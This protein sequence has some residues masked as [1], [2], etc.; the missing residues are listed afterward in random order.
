[1]RVFC[2]PFR[3]KSNPR[4]SRLEL[5]GKVLDTKANGCAMPDIFEEASCPAN[6]LN[7]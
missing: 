3:N 7:A 5:S 1:M 6:C 2:R 4:K